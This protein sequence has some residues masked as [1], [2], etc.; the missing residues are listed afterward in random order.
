MTHGVRRKQILLA[1]APVALVGC[2]LLLATDRAQC[3]TDAD[4]VGKAGAGFVCTNQVCISSSAQADAAAGDAAPLDDSPWGCLAAPPARVAEDR[5][6]VFTLRRRLVVF[7]LND[8]EHNRP[9]PG[10]EVKLC[11]LSDITCGSPVEAAVTDCGGY[12]TF[13][14]AYRGFRGFMLVT[15][16]FRPAADGGMGP[17]PATTTQCIRDLAATEAS[18]GRAGERCAIR[19]DD[20]GDVIVPIPDDLVPGVINVMPPPAS[21]DDPKAEIDI[22]F[23]PALMS[24]GTMRSFFGIL[25]K[26]LD[27]KAGHIMSITLDCQGNPSSG[28]SLTLSGGVGPSSQVYYTDLQALPNVNQGET[29]ERGE[30]GIM[31][32][33][34]GA[35]G[36]ATF[37]VT[38]T[39]KPT[40]KRL[41][42]YAFLARAGYISYMEMRPLRD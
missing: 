36:F 21:S 37:D 25:G 4:C 22:R 27:P 34:V 13:R 9:V 19:L 12:V 18:E 7:S 26:Q 20:K 1:I 39:H 30:T 8:C 40:G 42:T 6:K 14:A 2:Q 17:W 35:S 31:N 29:S 16:P 5:S 10:A 32:L 11:S 33:D 3:A 28:V 24:S 15:P 23:A 41:G 38:A